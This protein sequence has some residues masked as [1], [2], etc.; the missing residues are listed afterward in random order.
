[1]FKTFVTSETSREPRQIKDRIVKR[2]SA[3][4]LFVV[5]ERT[6]INNIPMAQWLGEYG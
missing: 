2:Q 6:E 1:M 4:A 5:I 3:Q